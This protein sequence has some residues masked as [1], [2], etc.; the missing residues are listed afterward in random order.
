VVMSSQ[1]VASSY[2]RKDSIKDFQQKTL[3]QEIYPPSGAV[4]EVKCKDTS[5]WIG[6]QTAG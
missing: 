6:L 4:Q 1:C 3:V 2:F 5:N